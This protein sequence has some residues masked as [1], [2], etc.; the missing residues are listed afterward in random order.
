VVFPVIEALHFDPY[1]FAIVFVKTVE[2]GLITP[3]LG[4]NTYVVSGVAKVPV[5]EGFAGVTPFLVADVI[6]LVLLA[7]FPQVSLFLPNLLLGKA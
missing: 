4:L 6:L 5:E 7:A 1:W 2:I 3:P